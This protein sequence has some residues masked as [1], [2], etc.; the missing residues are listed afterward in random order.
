MYKR[1]ALDRI[2]QWLEIHGEA[3]Y[4]TK[5]GGIYTES[6]QGPCYQYGMFTSKGKTAYL[7]IFYYP[8]DYIVISKIGP[9]IVSAEMLCTGEKLTVEPMKNARWKISGLPEAPPCD[10]APVTKIVFESEPY[11]LQYAD[12]EWMDGTYEAAVLP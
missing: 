2:G 10:L 6:V 8:G 4:G 12:G 3:V 7:T 5:P 9:G 11:E 1:Q